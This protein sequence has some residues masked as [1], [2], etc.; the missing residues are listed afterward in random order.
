M[1]CEG[2]TQTAKS[3]KKKKNKYKNLFTFN[4]IFIYYV[5]STTLCIER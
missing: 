2:D 1:L 4:R 3:E 5:Y